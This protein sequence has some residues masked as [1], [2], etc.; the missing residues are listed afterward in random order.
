M[1]DYEKWLKRKKECSI[2]LCHCQI[3]KIDNQQNVFCK[4]SISPHVKN[5]M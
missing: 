1:I 3:A 2:I 5:G 4:G